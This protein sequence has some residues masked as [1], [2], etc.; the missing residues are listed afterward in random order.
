MSSL[1][2]VSFSLFKVLVGSDRDWFQFE[3]LSVD[4]R[5]ESCGAVACDGPRRLSSS[6]AARVVFGDEVPRHLVGDRRDLREQL[7]RRLRTFR[8]KR[9]TERD[10]H[11]GT[12]L[13]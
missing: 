1:D 13:F 10:R 6:V 5:S 7:A 8:T 4:G 12:V 2:T 9:R 3:T 11:H